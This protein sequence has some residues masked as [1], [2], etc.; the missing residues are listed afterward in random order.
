MVLATA[1]EYKLVLF[2]TG[3]CKRKDRASAHESEG[4]IGGIDRVEGMELMWHKL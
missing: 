2:P 3:L 4:V 1:L